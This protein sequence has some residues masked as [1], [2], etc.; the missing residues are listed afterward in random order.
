[1]VRRPR[2]PERV[3]RAVGID[4]VGDREPT[5]A[6]SIDVPALRIRAR[7]VTSLPTVKKVVPGTASA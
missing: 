7:N 5:R 2:A 6:G 1:M 3:A 4:P